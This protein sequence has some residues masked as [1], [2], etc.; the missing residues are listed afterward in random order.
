MSRSIAPERRRA[1]AVGMAF[2][3]LGGI[4]FLIG[5]VGFATGGMSAVSSAGQSG[6][7]FTW[8]FV[9]LVAMGF[10]AAGAFVR[11]VAARG[12]AGSG[13]VLDPER[14]REDLEPYARAGGGLLRDALDESGLLGQD[15][16]PREPQGQLVKLRCRECRG[17][18]DE[19]ARFCSTCGAKL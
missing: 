13:L 18:N 4:A 12:V 5:F 9:C 19:S 14:A 8:W 2:Q 1:Y 17:L 6:S 16:P 15:A 3:V 10:L 7:P 11:R